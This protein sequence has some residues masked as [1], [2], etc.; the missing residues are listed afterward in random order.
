M[1]SM[2]KLMM[3]SA[4]LVAMAGAPMARAD[5]SGHAG[6]MSLKSQQ[7]RDNGTAGKTTETHTAGDAGSAP[8]ARHAMRDNKNM[9]QTAPKPQ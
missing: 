2:R 5:D 4:V 9:E 7:S 8:Q 6:P 1:T 3:A